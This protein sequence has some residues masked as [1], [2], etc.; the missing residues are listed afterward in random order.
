MSVIEQTLKKQRGVIGY[1]TA[2]DGGIART[3]EAQP[4][5]DKIIK[6]EKRG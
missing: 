3:K 4:L 6:L 2:G 5:W 1:L